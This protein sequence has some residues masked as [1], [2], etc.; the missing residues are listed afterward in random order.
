M[1]HGP[2]IV[3]VDPRCLLVAGGAERRLRLEAAALVERIIELAEG[4]RELAPAG[5]ELE[6]LGEPR[7]AAL[8]LGERRQLE[9]IVDD[10]GGLVQR[11]LDVRLKEL[12]EELGARQRVGLRDVRAHGRPA[13]LLGR[14]REHVAV[15]R[16]AERRHPL[17]ARERGRERG[18]RGAEGGLRTH[19]IG[20]R[21]EQLLYEEHHVGVVR[22][23]LVPLEHRELGVV[24]AVH[25]F[26]A[27]V[28][29]DLV[30][31]IEAADDQALEIELVR[32]AQVERNVECVVVRRERARRGAAIERLQ[33]RRLDLEEAPRVEEG[34]ER[35]DHP[36]A[37]HERR[38]HLGVHGEIDRALPVALLGIAEARVAHDGA[39]DDLLLAERE[40][41]QRLRQHLCARHAHGGLSGLRA[42]E[43]ARDADHVADVEELERLEELIAELVPAEVELDAAALVREVSEARLPVPAPR[44]DAPRHAHALP[45]L[46]VAERPAMAAAEVCVRLKP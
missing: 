38:A 26:V 16:A 39:V 4:V 31:G 27:E 23:R 12:V 18:H 10:E 1:L 34:A 24:R 30:H 42:E 40:R 21:H 28:V 13:E 35:A 14:H 19:G 45:L 20:S 9:R 6:A 29:A 2:E 5:E 37:R 7:R 33:Y 15:E 8:R 36:R 43:R 32:D 3:L 25:S 17:D 11:T 41:A 22:V 46:G 44:D